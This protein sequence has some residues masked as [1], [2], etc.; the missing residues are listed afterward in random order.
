MVQSV[1]EHLGQAPS[2]FVDL[3]RL[4]GEH[5]AHLLELGQLGHV[6]DDHAAA[7]TGGELQTIQVDVGHRSVGVEAARLPVR[8]AQAL[9]DL[10]RVAACV[11]PRVALDQEV[12][13]LGQRHHVEGE[14][15][16]HALAS[17]V[18]RQG[19]GRPPGR[20]LGRPVAD[21]AGPFQDLLSGQHASEAAIAGAVVGNVDERPFSWLLEL[22]G[23]ALLDGME[24]R[25]E[26]AGVLAPPDTESGEGD[27]KLQ[28][29][30]VAVLFE[31]PDLRLIL[32]EDG[33][34][35]GDTE[36][37]RPSQASVLVVHLCD[38]PVP[39]LVRADRVGPLVEDERVEH[40]IREVPGLSLLNAPDDLVRHRHADPP[41]V[42]LEP[43]RLVPQG[44]VERD[45][46][47]R[48]R[49]AQPPAMVAVVRLANR[50]AARQ[51]AG[52]V[53]EDALLHFLS[54]NVGCAVTDCPAFS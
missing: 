7:G 9:P 47:A 41:V 50:A 48:P 40:V 34:R 52:V 5:E 46:I 4:A 26:L 32:A 45:H 30:R 16:S 31:V 11:P 2:E 39:F 12:P 36:R 28:V 20:E 25:L 3:G 35:D 43:G 49:N 27:C 29:Q 10:G 15:A 13:P 14:I 17:H 38:D 24:P 37:L 33:V 1:P 23:H 54:P 51:N 42:L 8:L 6:E 44:P 53:N 22:E 18:G 21:V 19:V